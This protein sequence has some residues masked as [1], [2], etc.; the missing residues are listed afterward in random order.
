MYVT[1][2]VQVF[3]EGEEAGDGGCISKR[4]ETNWRITVYTYLSLSMVIAIAGAI[5][6]HLI[7]VFSGRGTPAQP[8][9]RSQL[10]PLCQMNLSF[11][12]FLRISMIAVGAYVVHISRKLCDCSS[13]TNYDCEKLANDLFVALFCMQ[14]IDLCFNVLFIIYVGRKSLPTCTRFIDSETRWSL[15]LRCLCTLITSMICCL[16]GGRE[17]IT[18]DFTDFAMILAEYFN[19]QGTLD[20]V[21]SDFVAGLQMVKRVQ[22]EHA[23]NCRQLL[24]E[25]AEQLCRQPE[26]VNDEEGGRGYFDDAAEAVNAHGNSMEGVTFR[27]KRHVDNHYQWE[28][29]VTKLLTKDN[30]VDVMTIAEGARFLKLS[31]AMYTWLMYVIHRPCTGLCKV[32]C[33][34]MREVCRNPSKRFHGDGRFCRLHAAAFMKVSGLKLPMLN[35]ALQSREIH[36]TQLSLTMIGSQSSL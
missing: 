17:T 16:F 25:R 15:F 8:E 1:K 18:A 34:S 28:P 24:L 6:E 14:L 19:L 23:D 12:M 36:P 21:P 13:P 31:M 29:T 11:M 22:Q 20:L 4:E 27:L 32:S 5:I 9:K 30:P 2:E 10:K 35:F 3:R 26:S 7:R 33:L